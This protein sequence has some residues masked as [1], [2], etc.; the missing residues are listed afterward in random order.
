MTVSRAALVLLAAA[1]GLGALVGAGFLPSDSSGGAS[2]AADTWVAAG[3]SLPMLEG[4]D[5]I[6]GNAV[7]LARFKDKP[8][9]VNVWA[10]W[11]VE[12]AAEAAALRRFADEHRA[13]VGLLGIDVEDSRIDARRFYREV[14]WQHPSIFDPMERL[15]ARL[16]LG[17]L[18]TTIFLDREHRVV[19]RIA[20]ASTLAELERA[21][22][23]AQGAS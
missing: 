7:T 20:G 8:L 16:N 17:Q 3:A 13:G 21:L 19:R 12:C 18:P 6:T 9:V 4:A 2:G 11:C 23:Q 10:S 1:I 14:G 15:A 5:V 22:R